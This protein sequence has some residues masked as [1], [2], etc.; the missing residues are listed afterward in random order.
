MLITGET[1]TSQRYISDRG[2]SANERKV[3]EMDKCLVNE[4]RTWKKKKKGKNEGQ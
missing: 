3:F 1:V 2:E 4:K